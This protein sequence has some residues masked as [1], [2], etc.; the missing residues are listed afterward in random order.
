MPVTLPIEVYE[1]FEKGF[2]KEDAKK[3]IKSLEAVIEADIINKWYETKTELKEELLKEVATK[4][5]L[6][7][8]RAELLGVRT[9][10]LGE[11]RKDRAELFGEMKKDRAEL[12]G[13]MKKDKAEL[14][15]KIEKEVLKLENKI[16]MLDRK[17][18]IMFI[19]LFFTIIF[20]NQN[21]LEFL[22]RIL[23]IVR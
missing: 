8:V 1:I 7:I 22:V 23:G 14:E 3:V 20:L 6:E 13:E 9:E 5:D 17:L 19:V 18:T 11:M 16:T 10:L 12:F 4:K 2:G 15:G 21:A